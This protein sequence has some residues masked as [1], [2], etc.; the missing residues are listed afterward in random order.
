MTKDRVFSGYQNRVKNKIKIKTLALFR[1]FS[2]ENFGWPAMLLF[3]D[4]AKLD[5]WLGY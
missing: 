5:H 1:A 2:I 3:S 4:R